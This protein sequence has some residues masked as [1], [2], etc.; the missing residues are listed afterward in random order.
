MTEN[1]KKITA[2][3]EAKGFETTPTHIKDGASV[4]VMTRTTVFNFYD[5][6]NGIIRM[7][8]GK[9]AS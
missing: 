7:I 1:I 6:G 5:E 8:K 9:K 4:R 3:I 2:A